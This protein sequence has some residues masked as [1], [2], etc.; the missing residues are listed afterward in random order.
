MGLLNRC[1]GKS[2]SRNKDLSF[3]HNNEESSLREQTR[4]AFDNFFGLSLFDDLFSKEGLSVA[5]DEDHV[6]IEAQVPGVRGE[7][8]D[9]SVDDN[10][11]LRIK[12]EGEQQI[13]DKKHYYRKSKNSFSYAI[14]LSDDVNIDTVSE[15][16]CERGVI[17]ISFDKFKKHGAV[18]KIKIKNKI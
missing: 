14:P 16:V 1:H 5:S 8:I 18:K 9:I 15:A 7:D 17:K 6:Y 2:C 13:E 10:R 4:S 12:A 11:V 3:D